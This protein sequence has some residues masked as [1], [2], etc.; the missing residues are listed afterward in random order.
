LQRLVQPG[1]DCERLLPD[2]DCG[3]VDDSRGVV[4]AGDRADSAEWRAEDEAVC[5]AAGELLTANARFV[6]AAK[7]RAVILLRCA[8]IQVKK[9]QH[10]PSL[11]FCG[12]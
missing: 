1:V 11:R 6:R 8:A 7:Q 9:G 12:T 4:F 5:V 10:E 2:S 3:Q